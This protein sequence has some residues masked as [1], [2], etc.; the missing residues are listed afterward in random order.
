LFANILETIELDDHLVDLAMANDAP[1]I[2]PGKHDDAIVTA[3]LD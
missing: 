2:P 3:R 1:K